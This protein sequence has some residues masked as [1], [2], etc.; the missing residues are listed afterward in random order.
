MSQLS[1][2]TLFTLLMSLLLLG[3]AGFGGGAW[4]VL[5]DLRV[6][7]PLYNN[8]VRGKDLVADILPPPAYVIESNL[9]A[10]QLVLATSPERSTLIQRL[11]ALEGEFKS[12]YAFWREQPLDAPIQALLQGAAQQSGR[13]FFAVLNSQLMPAAQNGQTEQARE[14]LYRMQEHYNDHRS[15]VDQ[16]VTLAS[17]YN[18]V[19]EETAT[20]H[21]ASG[22]LFAAAIFL[23]VYSLCLASAYWLS[24]RIL[25]IIGCE[26]QE[27]LR[28]VQQLAKG[29]L[30]YRQVLASPG[31]LLDGVQDV[32]AKMT[33]VMQRIDQTNREVGQSIFQVVSISKQIADDSQHQRQESAC[34]S[35][36]TQSLRQSLG[37]V[38]DMAQSAQIHTR[39]ASELARDGMQAMVKIRD[40]MELAVDRV[41]GSETSMRELAAATG[42]IHSIVS[43]IKAI[44]DQTNL[45]ALNAAIEAARAGEQGRGFAVVADEVRTLATRTSEATAQITQIVGGLNAKVDSS[46]LTMCQV[47]EAVTTA[48]SRTEANGEAINHIASAADA[49]RL[50][51]SKIFDAAQEQLQKIGELDN[52]LGKLFTTMRAHETTLKVTD[53]IS[54]SLHNTVNQL[55]EK[56]GFFKFES[57]VSEDL[58]HNNKRM[59]QRLRNSLLVTVM[60]G[61]NSPVAGVTQDFSLGGML[62]VTP[63]DLGVHK[64]DLIH[65][66]VKPPANQL[67]GYLNQSAIQLR[68]RIVRA[69]RQGPEFHYGVSFDGVAPSQQRD[70]E[71]LQA[72]YLR[73]AS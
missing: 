11:G 6:N 55:Q 20:E 21:L 29:D 47:A 31:S 71:I 62:L 4:S 39:T 27:A 72:Y 3:L 67:E 43:S 63:V 16:L 66:E 69:T 34:V 56:I 32:T 28:L 65:L 60:A 44:A 23:V 59:H 19:Q 7:G 38:Q 70:L 68:G 26:P 35:Q 45:L 9:L 64:R 42:E 40:Q 17:Q 58:H 24:R 14:A 5:E 13:D 37:D 41:L 54:N 53:T 52:H 22:K 8:I 51:S 36:A 57:A 50:A 10:H 48:Q 73:A 33:Q 25:A 18:Q 49:S 2:K 61:G 30:H 15:A 46:L 1:I 12:R